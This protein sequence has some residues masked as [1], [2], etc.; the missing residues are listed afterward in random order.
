MQ[1]AEVVLTDDQALKT[2]F[3][4][5]ELIRK[6]EGEDAE[7][8][9]EDDERRE[10]ERLAVFFGTVA[11]EPDNFRPTG[12]NAARVR[13]IVKRAKGRAQ[14][15]S[16]RKRRSGRHQRR[17]AERMH[18]RRNREQI[19]QHNAAFE[20][21]AKDQEELE[22]YLAEI[23]E[24]QADQPKYTIKDTAGRVILEGVP[25]EAIFYEDNGEPLY[26]APPKIIVPGQ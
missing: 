13:S 17:R 19:E 2:R 12:K 23:E 8:V 16:L 6:A 9:M 18:N 14:T 20:A 15:P 1:F 3:A 21:Y 22:K 11:A 25:A 7:Y 26:K 24:R 5:D 4:L 10:F